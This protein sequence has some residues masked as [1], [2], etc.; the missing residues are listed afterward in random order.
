MAETAIELLLQVQMVEGLRKVGPVK[1]SVD[2]EHLE[3]D[4]LAN[5]E[6]LLGEAAALADP[7][8]RTRQ[9]C[10]CGNLRVMRKRDP[11][12]LGGED[13]GVVNLA[14]NPPLHQSN[15]LICWELNGLK[16][17]V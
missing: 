7:V 5:V 10:R 12:R 8:V 4:G 15:V 14:R 16:A 3:E 17:A 9:K 2:A 1:V 11:R 13:L 6:K